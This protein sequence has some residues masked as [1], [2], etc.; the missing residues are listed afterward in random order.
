LISVRV[1]EGDGQYPPKN[2]V[3]RVRALS[4]K[5]GNGAAKEK[6]PFN[7]AIPF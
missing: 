5:S 6:V 3:G 1:E 7:D 2:E 4:A